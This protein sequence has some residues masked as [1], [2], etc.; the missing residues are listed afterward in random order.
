MKFAVVVT[1]C[2]CGG[3]GGGGGRGRGGELLDV[4]F[5]LIFD[6][7][8]LSFCVCVPVQKVDQ[9]IVSSPTWTMTLIVIRMR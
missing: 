7:E 5:G 3:G 9:Q 2:V 6:C 8:P 4:N 1:V